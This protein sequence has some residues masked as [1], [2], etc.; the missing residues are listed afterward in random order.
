MAKCE[1]RS[2]A[3]KASILWVLLTLAPATFAQSISEQAAAVSGEDFVR[4]FLGQCGQNAGYFRR[5]IEAAEA[6]KLADL[7]E[8]MRPLV[9]PQDPRAEF[10]GFYANTGIGAPYFLGVSK[11]DFRNRS[12]ITCAVANPYVDASSVASALAQ[13]ARVGSP[14]H[15]ETTMGQRYRV[16]SVDG[17]LQEAFISLTDAEPMGHDGATVAISAPNLE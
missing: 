17:W 3:L 10:V 14:D 9:A 5:V 2:N 11:G 12:F 8:S 16:W 7:P 13:F 15:D 6:L 4:A 1:C